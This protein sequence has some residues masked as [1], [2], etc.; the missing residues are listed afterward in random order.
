MTYAGSN[1]NP[2]AFGGVIQDVVGTGSK[3]LSLTIASGSL[4]LNGA[5]SYSGITKVNSGTLTLGAGNNLAT[6][7][8]LILNG[9]KF[10]SGG[11]SQALTTAPLTVTTNSTIDMGVG[12]ST[13]NFAN[14]NPAV[15]NLASSW[16]TGALLTINNWSGTPLSG[17]GIDQLVFGGDATG[18]PAA[19]VG[20]IKFS[21]FPSGATILATGEVVPTSAPYLIGDLNRDGH[22]NPTDISSLEQALTNLSGYLSAHATLTAGDVAY[23]GDLNADGLFDNADLQG[24]IDYLIQGHGSTTTVPE[25]ATW[26]LLLMAVMAGLAIWRPNS[27]SVLVNINPVAPL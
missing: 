19:E 11:Q 18:L 4:T 2:S 14:S 25:P 17:G 5:N 16:A 12:N 20:R 22:V 15:N 6:T 21:G 23:I 26:V 10:A 3:T 7:S 13:L 9:G 8:G 27:G 24:M 1:A